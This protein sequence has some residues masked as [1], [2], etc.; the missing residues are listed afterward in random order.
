M[1][2]MVPATLRRRAGVIATTAAAFTSILIPPASA[3]DLDQRTD[4]SAEDK[5]KV[6]RVLKAP[7]DFT[8]AENFELMQAGKS[9]TQKPLNRAV[10]TFPSAN[11]PFEKHQDFRLGE[12]LFQKLWVS[13]PSSTRAS[14]GLGPLFNARA[15]ESC[16]PKAGRGRPPIDDERPVSIFMRLS[17]APST[18]EERAR[19]ESGEVP[20]LPEPTYGG[21]L[22]NFGVPGVPGEGEM[23]ITYEEIKVDLSEGEVAYLR[24]PTYTIENLAYGPM[25]EHA[26]I[27]ARVAP[28]MIGL[29]LLE[30]IAETDITSQADP[31]DSDN[32]GISGRVSWVNPA[33]PDSKMIGRFG[34]KALNATVLSQS[35]G[36]FAGDI[37]ISTPYDLRNYGDC[38]EAQ[39]ACFEQAH[40]EQEHLGVSE[41][42][43]PV[44]DLVT[45]YSQNLAVP[46]RRDVSDAQVL[47]GK[48]VFY[49]AGCASC[50][51]PKYVT[52]RTAE[53]PEHQFQLIWPY[54][55]LL[56]HDMGEGLSDG[57]PTGSASGNEWKTPPLWGIGLTETV[58]NHRFFLHDGRARGLLEAVLWHG[59]EAEAAKT[60]VVEMPAKDR[61]N[62]IRFLESL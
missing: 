30:A 61:A 54:T 55:D 57:R 19:I 32:D 2:G 26:L 11:L 3:V 25:S 7:T 44:L 21:Q 40:G 15:C 34:W 16:H 45:F 22:Q 4:L 38:T 9:T 1:P 27:S 56:L 29:G 14:D 33:D 12:S 53:N 5:A 62:L 13:T 42:P 35:A 48:K 52:S 41:A 24:K 50:H 47:A 46:A 49:E 59:G 36:A 28:P 18:P 39:T 51:T 31:D 8:K 20:L 37:G 58:N 60:R 23:K 17:V 6:S 43:D 10:F